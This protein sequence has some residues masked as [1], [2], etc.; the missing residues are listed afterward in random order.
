MTSFN[1][2]IATIGRPSLQILLDS[3]L[4]QLTIDDHIT[5]V[6][7]GVKRTNIDISKSICSIHIFEEPVTLGYWGHGIRNKYADILV[8]ATF[9][10][11]ADDD[12][13]YLPNAFNEIKQLCTNHKQ[14][15]VAKIML[16]D[17]TIVPRGSLLYSRLKTIKMGDIGTPCGII[18]FELNRKSIWGYF[19]G[20][21]YSFYKKL[22]SI[23]RPTYLNCLIYIVNP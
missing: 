9:V 8:P 22:E 21:D 3:L 7:D 6:F 10:M 13:A 18:P 1:V 17:R 15:Y 23:I 14:W 16:S 19:Y 12:D 11:H 4:P 2:L 20:G 5:I